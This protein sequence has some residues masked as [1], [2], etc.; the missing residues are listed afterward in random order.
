[1]KNWFNRAFDSIVALIDR[2]VEGQGE[3]KVC[4]SMI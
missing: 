3:V 4:A 1:M 2:L